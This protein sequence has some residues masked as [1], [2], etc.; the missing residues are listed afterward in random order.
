MEELEKTARDLILAITEKT[1]K[2]LKDKGLL[3][4]PSNLQILCTSP[5]MTSL[6]KKLS[7]PKYDPCRKFRK[8]DIVRLRAY[9]GRKPYDYWHKQVIKNY[10]ENLDTVLENELDSGNV[11]IFQDAPIDELTVRVHSC[12]LELVTPGEELEP[13]SVGESTD[14]FS[15]DAKDGNEISCSWKDAHPNAKAGAEAER[16]RLNAE[17]R[18][19]QSHE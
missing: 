19:E 18:K 15:V 7:S 16:D 14:Y 1:L 13:Y 2:S 5:E 12:H 11:D 10:G 9:N 3:K 6:I 17:Y 4:K 8:G